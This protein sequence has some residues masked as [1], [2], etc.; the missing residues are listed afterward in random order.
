MKKFTSLLIAAAVCAI[1]VNVGLS[2]LA[3]TPTTNTGTQ[4]DTVSRIK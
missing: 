3:T 2:D 1:L 4:P